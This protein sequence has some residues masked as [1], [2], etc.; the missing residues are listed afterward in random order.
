MLQAGGQTLRIMAGPNG[1]I[2][3]PCEA[4]WGYTTLSVADWDHDGLPDLVV[5]SIWGKVVWYRNVGTRQRPQ[6]AAAAAGRGP[7]AGHA[8]QA[9]VELVEPGGQRTGHAVAHHADG[10]RS[11][12]RRLERPG[13]ARSGGLPG[14]LRAAEGRR[15][16]AAGAAAAHLPRGLESGCRREPGERRDAAERR[17]WPGAA[18]GANCA[19]PTGTATASWTCWPTAATPHATATSRPPNRRG[20]FETWGRWPRRRLAGHDT[21]PTVVD[22]DRDGKLDLLIG[23]EDGFFYYQPNPQARGKEENDNQP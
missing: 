8:A 4:K 14:V 17:A 18:G 6:L 19:W 1:S 21:S 16:A 23:A 5:N 20:H 22:W 10:R 3:G 2:Q 12:P 15:W 9:G 7:V 11:E 13:H